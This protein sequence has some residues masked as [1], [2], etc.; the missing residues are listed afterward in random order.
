MNLS[1]PHV[2]PAVADPGLRFGK[3]LNFLLALLARREGAADV[4]SLPFELTLDLSTRCQLSC[5]YCSV[6]NGSIRRLSGH[7]G[8]DLNDKVLRELGKTAFIAWYFSTGEPLLNRHAAEIFRAAREY[9]VFTVIST[10]LSLP[11][12]DERI[13]DLLGSGLGGICVSLDGVSAESYSRYRVGGDFGRVVDNLSRLV[14]RKRELGLEFPLIEWRFLVFRHNEGELNRARGMAARLGVDLLE[15][16]PGSAPPRPGENDV[17]RCTPG[18]R[19]PAPWGP[20]LGRPRRDTFLRRE[21]E[22]AAPSSPAVDPSLRHRKCDWLYFGATVFPGGS[23]GPCCVSNDEPDDFGTLDGSGT[24]GDIWNNGSY[25]AA[26]EIFLGRPAPGVVCARCAN[27][28]AHDYQFVNTLRAVLRNAPDW[29]IGILSQAPDRFFLEIDKALLPLEMSVLERPPAGLSPEDGDVERLARAAAEE[30]GS[31]R[32]IGMLSR[33]LESSV[34][35]AGFAGA[36]APGESAARAK[37]RRVETLLA[38]GE[39]EFSRGDIA[40]AIRTMREALEIDRAD[41]R[42]LNNLGVI[43]WHI[44]DAEAAVE[45]FQAALG[46]NPDDADALV[47]LAQAMDAAGKYYLLKPELLEM[48][49]PARPADRGAARPAKVAGAAAG[50]ADALKLAIIDSS[51]TWYA[52]PRQIHDEILAL[53]HECLWLARPNHEGAGKTEVPEGYATICIANNLGPIDFATRRPLD[54]SHPPLERAFRSEAD[55]LFV[56]DKTT[57]N[58]YFSKRPNAHYMPYAVNERIYRPLGVEPSFDVGF[59]GYVKLG[60]RQRRIDLLKRN[61]R[62]LVRHGLFMEDANAGMNACRIVF[63]TSDHREINMRVF[64]ALATGRLLV[65]DKVDYLDELF[66]DGEDLV[67]YSGE[68]DLM[69]KIRYYLE[70]EEE[71]LRIAANGLAKVREHHTYR[72]RAGFIVGK[73]GQGRRMPEGKAV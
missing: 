60:E 9:G 46:V 21:L 18:T 70:H 61:F 32:R 23:A 1:M 47:N 14:R 13:D 39:G 73:V 15:F 10:N 7:F 69:D 28:D 31:A 43:Q 50:S 4:R 3:Y 67:T 64:E 25:R 2:L 59:I 63:N 57:F 68:D 58:R 17:R 33:L 48:L 29:V 37:G 52:Q 35:E 5:P 27:R 71:R 65:T 20:V 12:S 6:G 66:V 34:K 44:G 19:I 42:V 24:F 55:H 56:G 8:P 72:H 62:C 51:D 41:S 53:G 36:A 38:R 26:R 16:Y 54:L 30:D 45:T 40:S 11:L 22:S 49:K